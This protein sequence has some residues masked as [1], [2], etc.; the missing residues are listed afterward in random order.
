MC[1]LA[2]S[3]DCQ[4]FP[5]I[6]Q[7]RGRWNLAQSQLSSTAFP[8]NKLCKH[9]KTENLGKDGLSCITSKRCWNGSF[10]LGAPTLLTV[11]LASA[12]LR[13]FGLVASTRSSHQWRQQALGGKTLRAA[14][15]T[16]EVEATR[17]IKP[18]SDTKP[19]EKAKASS[20]KAGKKSRILCRCGRCEP[21]FGLP[22]KPRVCCAQCKS[23]GMVDT[24]HPRCKCGRAQA[25][26]GIPGGPREC[27][28]KCKSKVMVDLKEGR[29]FRCKALLDLILVLSSKCVQLI[30]HVSPALHFLIIGLI[31]GLKR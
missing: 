16:V 17:Q 26:Y 2:A 24:K 30:S 22:G 27:C 11:A 14:G 13:R 1:A 4:S 31:P 25:S 3:F 6:L 5:A 18:A 19:R 12:C 15:P 23:E 10:N 20:I 7:R 21:C 8:P 28:S 9:G 29:A